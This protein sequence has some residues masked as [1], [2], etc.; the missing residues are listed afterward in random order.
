MNF[1]GSSGEKVSVLVF[2]ET[3]PSACVFLFCSYFAVFRMFLGV[4]LWAMV[5]GPQPVTAQSWDSI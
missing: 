5:S 4:S 1:K 2:A 3:L